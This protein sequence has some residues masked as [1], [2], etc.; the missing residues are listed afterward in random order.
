MLDD[1]LPKPPRSMLAEV[2]ERYLAA[3]AIERAVYRFLRPFLWPL[4]Q[5][6]GHVSRD[7]RRCRQRQD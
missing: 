7:R 3:A 6:S 4:R 2:D 5:I 1:H